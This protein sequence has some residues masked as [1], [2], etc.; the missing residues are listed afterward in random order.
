M[1]MG[2]LAA[3]KTLAGETMPE[4]IELEAPLITKENVAFYKGK[5][6]Y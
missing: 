4:F 5:T 6:G 1:P 3:A 2:I